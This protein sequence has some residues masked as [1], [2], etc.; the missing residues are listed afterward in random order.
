MAQAQAVAIAVPLGRRHLR[1]GEERGR[2]RAVGAEAVEGV[3]D[4]VDELARDALV[5][6]ALLT[7]E[8]LTD[9][10]RERVEVIGVLRRGHLQGQLGVLHR[11]E[12]RRTGDPVQPVPALARAVQQV[13]VDLRRGLPAAD[14]RDRVRS[15]AARRGGRRS[16]SCGS[17]G[18]R[19]R[20][21]PA[22]SSAGCRRRAPRAGPAVRS[23][24][25]CRCAWRG[26]RR[27]RR[28]GR[29]RWR[30]PRDSSAGSAA[31]RAA[32][33]QYASYSARSA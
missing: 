23:A 9:A 27:R 12:P 7:A 24:R 14:H 8:V 29:A 15:R 22:G 1:V 13:A 21:A 19:C 26:R 10:E 20:A 31:G 3:V 6:A 28:R 16:P 5:E 11:E 33:R 32:H 17:R 25:R 2:H 4:V 30:R 18:R